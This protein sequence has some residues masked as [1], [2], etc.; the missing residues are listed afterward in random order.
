MAPSTR[1]G[2]NHHVSPNGE[3]ANGNHN[4][5]SYQGNNTQGIGYQEAGSSGQ[6]PYMMLSAELVTALTL[7][8]QALPTQ[9]QLAQTQAGQTQNQ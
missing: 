5:E 6:P 7:V 4:Q 9:T 1:R 3:N 8:A 2:G